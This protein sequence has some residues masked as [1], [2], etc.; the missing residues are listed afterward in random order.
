MDFENELTVPLVSLPEFCPQVHTVQGDVDDWSV[1]ALAPSGKL[2]AANSTSETVVTL[3]TNCTSFILGSG[4]LIY[5]TSAHYS[6]YA[7]LDKLYEML[8]NGPEG[9]PP[10]WEQRRVE[11]GS[12]IVT[13]V[14]SAMSLVLQ[15]PR[16]NLETINPRPLVLAVVRQ[17]I[18]A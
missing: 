17:D 3:A 18:D 12:R 5:T 15:M 6:H 9:A 10:E 13:V 16:G 1:Y 11:R 7:P 4:F 14:P 2:Y 8:Q